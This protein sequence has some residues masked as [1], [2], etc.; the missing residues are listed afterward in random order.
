ML[1]R[2][3]V[4]RQ[5]LESAEL[6]RIRRLCFLRRVEDIFEILQRD[7]RLA[8]NVDDISKFLQRPENKERVN[9][10]R[11]ELSDGD[12]L[13]E[14]QIQHQ[15]HDACPQEVHGRSLHKA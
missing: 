10:E 1:K 11:E 5:C 12:L 8:V 15:E 13:R 2:Y 9:E 6:H 7:F 4:E 14:N 3:M